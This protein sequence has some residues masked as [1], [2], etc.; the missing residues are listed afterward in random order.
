MGIISSNQMVAADQSSE[1]YNSSPVHTQNT[2]KSSKEISNN[3][4]LTSDTALI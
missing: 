3:L 2:T 4:L 1:Q